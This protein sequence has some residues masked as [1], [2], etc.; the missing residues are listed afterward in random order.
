MTRVLVTGGSGFIGTKTIEHL[1]ATFPDM[2]IRGL[3]LDWPEVNG[4]ENIR[5]SILDI[6]DVGRAVQDCDYV[7]HIAAMLGVSAPIV[8]HYA[9][10]M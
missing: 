5:G 8:N 7:F 3:D 10:S 2:A 1:R 9:V 6:D 4:I